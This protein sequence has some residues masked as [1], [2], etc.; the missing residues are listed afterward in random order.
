MGRFEGKTVIVTGAGGGIGRCHALAFAREGANVVVNDLGVTREGARAGQPLAEGVAE[1]IRRQGGRAVADMHSVAEREGA[2]GILHTALEAFGRVD[3]L[4]N[5]AGIL[6]DRTI[7]KMSDEEWDAVIAVHLRGTFLCTQVVARQL[8]EQGEGGA[9]INT[10]STSGLWGNFG[11]ANYGA[12]KAGIAGF[13]F[14]AALEFARY[15]IRVNAIVPVAKTRMT[16]DISSVPE[17]LKPEHISPLVLY[18]ASDLAKGVTG[19]IFG[20]YGGQVQEY[21]LE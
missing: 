14:T 10:S 19:R 7:L 15:G 12:A 9:I 3:V 16:E 5:N 20:I 17:A 4:V 8:V 1:E 13:T 2:E 6:R 18:L 21:Y 11:Q